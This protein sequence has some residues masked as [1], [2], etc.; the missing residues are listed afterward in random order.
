MNLWKRFYFGKHKTRMLSERGLSGRGFFN[1]AQA[2][3]PILMT[4][5]LSCRYRK[6]ENG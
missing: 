6:T 5:R 3:K 2:A 4:G 1:C